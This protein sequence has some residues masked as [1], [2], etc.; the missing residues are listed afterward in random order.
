M[1]VRRIGDDAAL[2]FGLLI[3]LRMLPCG[4]RG[5]HCACEVWESICI[6]RETTSSFA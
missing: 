1:E 5:A 4:G 6:T 2:F 3:L